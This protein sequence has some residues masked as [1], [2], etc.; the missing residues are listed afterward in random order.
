MTSTEELVAA[1][2]KLLSELA[3]D[4]R[5]GLKQGANVGKAEEKVLAAISA[6]TNETTSPPRQATVEG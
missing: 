4:R 6:V 1:V 5:Y 2:R 3:T